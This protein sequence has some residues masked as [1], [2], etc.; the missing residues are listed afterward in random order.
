MKKFG[1]VGVLGG[2]FLFLP[3]WTRKQLFFDHVAGTL[4][5][6]LV[7]RSEESRKGKPKGTNIGPVPHWPLCEH[8]I[9]ADR[10]VWKNKVLYRLGDPPNYNMQ[11]RKTF[12]F[13]SKVV[14]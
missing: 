9:A 13:Q 14:C 10:N 3:V 2:R 1:L 4:L 6:S 8:W 12:T 11:Q 5:E 7:F